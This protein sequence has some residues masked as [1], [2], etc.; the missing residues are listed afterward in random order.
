MSKREEFIAKMSNR[1]KEWSTEL[2]KLENSVQTV[3]SKSQEKYRQQIADLRKKREETEKKLNEI[4]AAGDG[5]WE[6]TKGEA[7]RA[8]TALK[9][10]YA[11]FRAHY[12][13][14]TDEQEKTE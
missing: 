6:N 10:G 9:D 13:D 2:D 5:A 3:K 7:E 12:K 14:E 8:W 1:L 4:R 11:A